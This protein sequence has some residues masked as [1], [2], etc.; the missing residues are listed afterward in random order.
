MD[1]EL[2][3]TGY[4]NVHVSHKTITGVLNGAFSQK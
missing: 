2:G 3:T 4:I 1:S